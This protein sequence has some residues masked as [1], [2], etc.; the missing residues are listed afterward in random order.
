M[1]PVSMT[2][3]TKL[4]PVSAT[5]AANFAT[6]SACVVD[7]VANLP[8]VSTIS[9][10]NLP[11]VLTTP[12]AN[13]HRYQRHRW[14]IM[15]TISGCRNLK[16]NLK[17]KMYIYVNYTT[18]RCPNKIIKILLLEDFF[19]LPPVSTTPV[20]HLQPR[21]S[22]RILEKIRNSRNGIPS[23]WGKL[24]HENNQKSKFR[25]TVPL[26]VPKCEIFH[27]FDFNDFY[28]IKSL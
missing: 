15:V 1:P 27:L 19:H 21:I 16:V 20:V 24:I 23:A 17:A 22:S 2:P 25:D 14:Q 5:P 9:A 7:T 18:Q 12:V 11:P 6:S 10:A 8:P 26:K 4:P 13:C 28:G 3:V